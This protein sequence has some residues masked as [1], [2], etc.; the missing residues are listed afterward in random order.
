MSDCQYP[1]LSASSGTQRARDLQIRRFLY[2]H[3][4]PF[5]TVRDL[6]SFL[7]VVQAGPEHRKFV[8]PHGSQRGSRLTTG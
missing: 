6:G 7:R 8:H 5:R 3:P 1:W 4:V 2:L